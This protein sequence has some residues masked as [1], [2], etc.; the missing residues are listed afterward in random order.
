MKTLSEWNN[1]RSEKYKG[2][3]SHPNNISCPKCGKELWDGDPRIIFA[4]FPPKI[5]VF[6]KDCGFMD[7]RV[8]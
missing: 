2:L 8:L 7:Y 6:C 4:S 1:L 3:Q 5:K